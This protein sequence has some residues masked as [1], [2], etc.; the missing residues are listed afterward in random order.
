MTYRLAL[1]VLVFWLQT[2]LPN[3]ATAGPSRQHAST[4]PD[5]ASAFAKS[6]LHVW[7]FEEYD[8]VKRTPKERARVLKE[9]GITKAGYICRNTARVAEFE[10]YV[11]AYKNEGIE[12]I[13]V[14]TPVHTNAPLEEPQI[15]G[16]FDVVD[17]HTL[18]IQ[19]W[20][21]LEEDFDKLP[22]A[23]RVDHAVNRL[24]PLV[25]EA[26]KR[27]CRLVTYGHGRT[28]WFTQSENQIAI[29]AKLKATMPDAQLGIVYNFH[30]SHGQMDRLKAV[31]PQLKPHLVALNLNGM[32]S[33]GPQ[34]ETL[35]KGDREREMIDII[36]K[37]GW[38]GPVGI[39]GHK[40]SEDVK[41]TLQ[42][43]LDGLRS[44]LTEI[45]D[46]AGSS[47]F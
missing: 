23:S 42:A 24:R 16:F 12:L 20:L 8:A 40:R 13:A 45:G 3:I 30:Q 46:D 37:S 4:V 7:A 32:R 39:I 19:W 33:D 21:T 35:G 1:I 2:A 47:T 44:I 25:I 18:R 27:G 17:R 15:R 34:I 10:A 29:V 11:Q 36:F 41:P 5:E 38:R 31:F 26:N 6:N 22:A 14:W 28:K 9:L 43:N